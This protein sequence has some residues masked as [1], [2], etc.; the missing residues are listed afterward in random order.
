MQSRVA[1]GRGSFAVLVAAIASILA[2]IPLAAQEVTGQKIGVFDA[3][4]IMAESQAG[5]QALALF[6]QLRDQ[7]VG[8]VQ[9][10]QNQINTLQQQAIAVAPGSADGL[11]LQREVENSMLR[12]N[13]L[14]EDVEQEL[15]LRQ[16]ELTSEI[17]QMIGEVIDV[18]GEEEGYTLIFNSNQSGLVYVATALD[19]TDEII[20]R[21]DAMSAP[22][23]L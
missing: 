18:M 10:Q 7:R 1:F 22:D 4:R 6:N 5:Q 13:R 17:T 19:V 3:D 20:L 11:R 9:V 2:G 8:E 14:Q 16:N 23:T 12:L 15:G 21:I